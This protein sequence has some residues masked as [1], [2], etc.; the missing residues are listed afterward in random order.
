MTRNLLNKA[1]F[2]RRFILFLLPLFFIV[3]GCDTAPGADA[4]SEVTAE[5]NTQ[6]IPAELNTQN[7]PRL[8]SAFYG[9]DNQI[10][11]GIPGCQNPGNEDG[12]PVVFSRTLNP[13]SIQE[14]DFEIVS[15]SG[16]VS[17]PVCATPLPAVGP[18]EI[19]TILLIGEFGSPDDQPERVTIVG[20]LFSDNSAGSPVNFNGV[21]E[22]VVPLEEGPSLA[23]AE[24]VPESQL[25]LVQNGC[26]TDGTVQVVRAVWEGGITKPGGAEVDDLERELYR[27]TIEDAQGYT[28]EVIPFAFG[29]LNDND[30]NHLLCLDV[31]GLPIRVSFPEGA[32]T[33]PN[34][35]LNPNTRT[36]VEQ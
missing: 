31:E 6:T 12:M 15:A 3:H 5:R 16:Q 25:S 34:D 23:L 36:R 11:P 17:T 21:A 13:L 26:P 33:D 8:L 24:I 19:R 9:L 18:G 29:D 4:V 30:N 2:G 7:P 10:I 22:R 27:V 20:D 35:D 14:T 1:I 32:M 28:S